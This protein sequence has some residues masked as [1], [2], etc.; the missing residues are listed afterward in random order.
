MIGRVLLTLKTEW[1]D[2]TTALLFEPVELLERLAALTPR[3]RIN[4]VLHPGVLA[5]HSRWR[6]RAVAYG[7]G[8]LCPPRPRRGGRVRHRRVARPAERAVVRR[9]AGGERRGASR[10]DPG[11]MIGE[12]KESQRHLC[13]RRVATRPPS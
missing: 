3:P 11:L 4:L 7:A 10:R 9:R 8:H 5:S 6:A 1:S 12:A 13:R 2:G